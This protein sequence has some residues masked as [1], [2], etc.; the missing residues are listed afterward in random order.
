MR[1]KGGSE[2][3]GRPR[4]ALVAVVGGPGAGQLSKTAVG[5]GGGR[6]AKCQEQS[7]EKVWAVG[8]ELARAQGAQ[9]V[10][11]PCGAEYDPEIQASTKHYLLLVVA[12]RFRADTKC[13]QGFPARTNTDWLLSLTRDQCKVKAPT[14]Q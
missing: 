6:L 3:L 10:K 11:A 9:D 14:T 1:P 8:E 5:A 4:G 2:S 7:W 12:H 13:G